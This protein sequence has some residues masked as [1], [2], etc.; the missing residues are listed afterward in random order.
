MVEAD[1]TGL[2]TTAVEV[3]DDPPT[4]LH[5]TRPD[6]KKLI[7]YQQ[8]IHLY[9]YYFNDMVTFFYKQGRKQMQ[10]GRIIWVIRL[11]NNI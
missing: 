5:D 10:Q 7:G 8:E 11:P 4:C 2:I 9:K 6:R 1:M 3:M